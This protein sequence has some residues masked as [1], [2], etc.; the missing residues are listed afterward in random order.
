MAGVPWLSLW[1]EGCLPQH[2]DRGVFQKRS[3]LTFKVPEM[4]V[5]SGRGVVE[6]SDWEEGGLVREHVLQGR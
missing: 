4:A 5:K 3:P 6:Q 1:Y 2:I